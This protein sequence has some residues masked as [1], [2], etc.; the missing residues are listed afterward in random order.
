MAKHWRMVKPGKYR[1]LLTWRICR[2]H[3][4]WQCFRI[5]Q[6]MKALIRQGR[7]RP[8]QTTR[9]LHR[10]ASYSRWSRRTVINPWC[11]RIKSWWQWRCLW[12]VTPIL[13][14]I[15]QSTC[16]GSKST[17]QSK[18]SKQ[19]PLAQLK[20]NL[21]MHI[22]KVKIPEGQIKRRNDN[23]QWLGK[24][25]LKPRWRKNQCLYPSSSVSSAVRS[26]SSSW[27]SQNSCSPSIAS[28]CTPSHITWS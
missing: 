11:L 15:R 24:R 28:Q 6:K 3:R 1:L 7:I 26:T 5:L 21:R 16:K 8:Q 25:V 4:N 9:I 18:S 27:N 20:Q 22:Q 12:K 23:A 10:K 17:N 14:I 2:G 13:V 19:T